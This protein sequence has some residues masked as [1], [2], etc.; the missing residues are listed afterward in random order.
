MKK[1]RKKSKNTKMDLEKG[2]HFY[3]PLIILLWT[4]RMFIITKEGKG[5]LYLTN[6]MPNSIK[7]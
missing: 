5:C 6:G 3:F 7:Y 2:N 1:Q 4:I